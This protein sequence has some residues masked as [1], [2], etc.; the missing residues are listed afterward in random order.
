MRLCAYIFDSC[1]IVTI[2]GI[3]QAVHDVSQIISYAK[4]N[5]MKV[6]IGG[7]SLGGHVT[8]FLGTCDDRVDLYVMGQAGAGLPESLRYLPVCLIKYS[9]R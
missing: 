3:R 2:E 8:A 9:Q 5:Y 7:F 6:I 4:E 1:P